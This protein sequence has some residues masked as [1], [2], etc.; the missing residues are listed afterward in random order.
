ME[1]KAPT[2]AQEA[3]D[4]LGTE[5]DRHTQS[6]ALHQPTLRV[7]STLASGGCN[8][9]RASSQELT[10]RRTRRPPRVG[11]SSASW[12]E[13]WVKVQLQER[14]GEAKGGGCSEGATE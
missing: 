11:Q 2:E 1:A 4:R 8:P 7:K 3:R 6:I 13:G 5:G 10:V 9:L 14:G 12:R